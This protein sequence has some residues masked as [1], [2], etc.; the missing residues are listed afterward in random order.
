MS[1]TLDRHRYR[2]VLIKKYTKLDKPQLD[3]K[4]R[5]LEAYDGHQL[6]L[7]GPPACDVKWSGSRLTQKQL[8]VVQSDKEVGLLG[9]D[10]L[11]KHD[12]NN[13]TTEHLPAAKGYKAHVKLIPGSQ[14]LFCK[15]RKIPLPIQEK[16]TEKREQ[17]VRLGI[18][19]PVQ[20]GGV[21]I[22]SSV[23]WQRN[24]NGESIPCKDL[25]VHV[26]GKVVDENYTIPDMET[27]FQKLHEASYFGKIDLSAYYQ[28]ELDEEAKDICTINSPQGLFKMCRLPQGLKKLVFNLPELRR[29][30][31]QENQGRCHFSSRCVGIWNY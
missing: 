6:T 28:I 26:N 5:H 21:T 22:E 25:K 23:V 14:P 17:M 1:A 16:V 8:T 20:P 15:A 19:K 7:L 9:R 30:N 27:I 3:G 13:I 4:T 24:K 29:I 18:F 12:V 2:G 31:T 11:P 10:L